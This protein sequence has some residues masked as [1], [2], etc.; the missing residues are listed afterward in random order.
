[1]HE[2]GVE[3]ESLKGDTV[4]GKQGKIFGRKKKRERERSSGL[5]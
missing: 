3:Q 4:D 2:R 5:R 1:M